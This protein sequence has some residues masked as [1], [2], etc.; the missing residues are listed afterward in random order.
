MTLSYCVVCNEPI[1]P[2]T[3][4]EEHIINN[5]IG[6]RRKTT[7]FICKHDNNTTGR[8]WDAELASQLN[9]LCHLFWIKR[10]RGE[11]P[12]ETVTTSAGET[13]IMLPDGGFKLPKPVINKKQEGTKTQIQAYV[14]TMQEARQVLEGNKRK[15]P[16]IDVATELAKATKEY[17]FPEGMIKIPIL[18][19]GVRSG[20]SIVKSAMAF[21]HECGIPAKACEE[22]LAYLRDEK[23]PACFGYYQSTDLVVERPA[24]VPFHCVAISGDPESGLL[25]GYV[26]YFGFL[27]MVVCLSRTYSGVPIERC[28]AIDPTTGQDLHLSMRMS[29]TAGD[30]ADIFEDKH[31]SLDM[32]NFQKVLKPALARKGERDTQKW[33]ADTVIY[34][35]NNCGAKEGEQLTPE[36]TAKLF[37]LVAE[38][39]AV[40][41]VHL[42]RPRPVPLGAT[43]YPFESAT[44]EGNAN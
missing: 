36:Q 37:R 24:G 9:G 39:M 35:F 17:S 32:Q 43:F 41:I 34:A 16:S 7:G 5:A 30:I 4:S 1:T 15:Y 22:A 8:T 2:D 27:R 42:T 28:H 13:F 38:R 33:M 23:V 11:I 25:L 29:F 26:E 40:Y 31:C 20:R 44:G 21:A 12:E 14:R 18:I 3:D 6:G 19:G 10:E